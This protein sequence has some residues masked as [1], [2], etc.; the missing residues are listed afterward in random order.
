MVVRTRKV[1]HFFPSGTVDAFDIWVEFEAL[2]AAGRRIF[3]SGQVQDG[4]GPVDPGAH[5]YRAVQVDAR[6]T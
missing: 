4:H 2:D 5:F 6:G 3:W 1:G